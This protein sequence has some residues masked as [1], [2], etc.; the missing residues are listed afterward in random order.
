M[1]NKEKNNIWKSKEDKFKNNFVL[2][3]KKEFN[4]NFKDKEKKL[5]L[6]I[7]SKLEIN[8]KLKKIRFTNNIIIILWMNKTNYRTYIKTKLD[9]YKFKNKNKDQ[10]WKKGIQKD[11]N[12]DQLIRTNK[13]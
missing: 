7:E 9:K 8:C 2:D 6:I 10:I 1:N 13:S 12:R 5:N 3:N 4:K 11:F